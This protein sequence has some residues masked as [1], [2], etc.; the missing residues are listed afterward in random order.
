MN[1]ASKLPLTIEYLWNVTGR[2]Y[3]VKNNDTEGLP[4]EF[5]INMGAFKS[6]GLG[7]CELSNKQIITIEK[8]VRGHMNTRIPL[9]QKEVFGILNIFTPVYG[10]LFRP[11]TETTGVYEISIFE[12]TEIQGPA[13][14]IKESDYN[15]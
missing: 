13:F 14:L 8:S 7:A 6:K 1:G 2:V 12:D 10:Y 3:I 5:S 4:K 15:G 11:T 9:S